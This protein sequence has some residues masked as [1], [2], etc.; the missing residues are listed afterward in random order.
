[1]ELLCKQGFT[2]IYDYLQMTPARLIL[3]VTAVFDSF[4]S[5]CQKTGAAYT[6]LAA[7]ADA[8]TVRRGGQYVILY[9]SEI[10]SERRRAFT[11]A[12][13][14]GHILLSHAGEDEAAE[15]REANAF[16]ASLLAPEILFRFLEHRDGPFDAERMEATFCLSR[17]AAENRL[18][19]LRR[20]APRRPSDAEIALL[21]SLFGKI[22]EY[23]E[24]T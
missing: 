24:K 2:S 5:F 17:E 22:G 4:A 19:D 23:Q 7:G 21:L 1:V 10:K 3:P 15:E 11:L 12:H 14:I 16:A 9:N 13:E 18:R 6:K 8:L 20:R